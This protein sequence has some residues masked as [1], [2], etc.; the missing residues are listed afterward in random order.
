MTR[1]PSLRRTA[2]TWITVLLAVAGLITTGAAYRYSEHETAG[3][4]DGQI[5][6]IALNAGSGPAAI[7]APAATDQDPEDRFAVTL[8]NAAGHITH[9][10][11]PGAMIPLQPKSGFANA[12]AG[13]KAWRVY[14]LRG[15]TQSVQVAQR[16]TV[17]NEIANNAAIGAAL[18]VLLLIPLSWLVVGLALHR[19]LRRLD[20][21]AHDLSTRG[22]LATEKLPLAAVPIE[23]TPLV[24]GMNGLILRLNTALAAQKRFVSDAAHTLRTPI[25]AMQI[26]IGNLSADTPNA[27]QRPRLD[28]LAAATRRAGV[29]VD[30]L[31]RLAWLDEPQPPHSTLFD[32]AGLLLDCVA[33]QAPL[34]GHQGVD[35][36]ADIPSRAMISGDAQELR[37]LFANLIENALLY[38]PHG[39]KL[40][41]TLRQADAG[42]VADLLDTG[43]GL[44]QG[45]DAH[46]FKRFYRAAPHIAVG[47]GLGLAIAARIAERHGFTLEVGNRTDGTSGVLARLVMPPRV[48][49]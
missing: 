26:E 33:D 43:P 32:V 45:S 41:V 18:P 48:G 2:L 30:Q 4:L 22:A 40:D 47:S 28:A 23:L 13:G 37:T 10:S 39:G 8:W 27:T 24:E 21:L 31:L 19:T 29:L 38:T 46:L 9:Q 1:T 11:L 12:R 49:P 35:L 15:K 7:H 6:Q 16:M 14:T 17:R 25:A 44:P 3:F 34:A 5:R 20:A 36:G 42:F